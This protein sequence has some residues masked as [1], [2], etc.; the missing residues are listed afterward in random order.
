MI[1]SHLHSRT[2][3]LKILEVLNDRLQPSNP[4]LSRLFYRGIVGLHEEIVQRK[5]HL[6]T[7]Q[8][9]DIFTALKD[10]HEEWINDAYQHET[11]EKTIKVS[12]SSVSLTIFAN[13][14]VLIDGGNKLG[15]G[16]QK[17]VY[18]T[19]KLMPAGGVT[20]GEMATVVIAR[21]RGLKTGFSP[22]TDE[23]K[24]IRTMEYLMSKL[25]KEGK[26]VENVVR[27]QIYPI[28]KTASGRFGGFVLLQDQ[29][30]SDLEGYWR[31]HP[32]RNEKE[33]G[34]QLKQIAKGIRTI[35]EFG[36]VHSDLKPAN[37]FVRNGVP[38]VADFG[39]AFDPAIDA[40]FGGTPG[41]WAP[42]F[43]SDVSYSTQLSDLKDESERREYAQKL[44]VFSWGVTA[45]QSYPKLR[46]YY[47]LV[48]ECGKF[49]LKGCDNL[50]E[51]YETNVKQVI[52]WVCDNYEKRYCL[53]QVAYDAINPDVKSRPS[54]NEILTRMEN[55]FKD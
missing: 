38:S 5:V 32:I 4:C 34:K 45:L 12:H 2:I 3:G 9:Y 16:G 1:L 25:E 55:L 28:G 18:T 17:T 48:N 41:F 39:M 23:I 20:R 35:H 47:P 40:G 36:F 15:E 37:V 27:T 24:T 42:E 6:S 31:K 13:G 11:G 51:I 54:M 44:D 30:D 21:P 29:Q 53:A 33:R 14:E 10:H 26:P 19:L 52:D 22:D 7:E 8:V 43:N 50:N 46:A 49:E